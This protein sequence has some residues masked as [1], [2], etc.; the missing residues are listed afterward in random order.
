VRLAGRHPAEWGYEVRNSTGRVFR[1]GVAPEG[2]L[3]GRGTIE[4]AADAEDFHN[5]MDSLI[6]LL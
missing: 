6:S 2:L 4:Q 5:F 3:P 1:L